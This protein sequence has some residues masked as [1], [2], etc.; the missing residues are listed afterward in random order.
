MDLRRSLRVV[1]SA[2]KPVAPLITAVTTLHARAWSVRGARLN[3]ETTKPTRFSTIPRPWHTDTRK[4]GNV[5][6][7]TNRTPQNAIRANICQSWVGHNALNTKFLRTR[8]AGWGEANG[9]W[10]VF[11]GLKIVVIWIWLINK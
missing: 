2:K 3:R 4:L 5:G 6:N 1:K 7:A 11:Y 8:D 10:F 9:K